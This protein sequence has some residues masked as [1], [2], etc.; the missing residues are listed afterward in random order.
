ML[1]TGGFFTADNV[2]SH[3]EEL[4][5]FLDCALADARLDSMVVPIGKGVLVCRKV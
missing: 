2:T 1:A 4:Q 3:Q 5:H